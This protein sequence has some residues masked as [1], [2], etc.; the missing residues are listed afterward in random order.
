MKITPPRLD[1]DIS[2]AELLQW[3]LDAGADESIGDIPLDRFELTA[4]NNAP[5]AQAIKQAIK[6]VHSNLQNK[7]SSELTTT[8]NSAQM[9]DVQTL[10]QEAATLAAGCH[11]LEDLETVI[12]NFEG[13]SLKKTASNTVFADGNPN[14]RLMIIGEA[15]GGAWPPGSFECAPQLT[16]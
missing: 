2:H 16:L 8:G 15:P 9:R 7:A 4:Q 3:Y 6:K 13:C 11:R 10:Q 1:H 14:G 12:R 5:P